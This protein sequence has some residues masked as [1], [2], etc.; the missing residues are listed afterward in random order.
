M[1]YSQMET[2]M[3]RIFLS[4][5]LVTGLG[6]TPIVTANTQ[7]LS[8]T[9]NSIGTEIIGIETLK[10]LALI[11]GTACVVKI[12]QMAYGLYSYNKFQSIKPGSVYVCESKE[13]I[14]VEYA[15]QLPGSGWYWQ[16]G[17][18]GRMAKGRF[19]LYNGKEITRDFPNKLLSEIGSVY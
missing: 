9:L 7:D 4:L 2:L 5:I 19:F 15:W 12:A 1:D 16:A 13:W 8:G 3:K 17:D 10:S 18:Y 14:D 11:V 6:I